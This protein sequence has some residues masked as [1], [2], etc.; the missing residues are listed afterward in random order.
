[1]ENVTPGPLLA[2]AGL[3]LLLLLGIG[4]QQARRQ[5]RF[6]SPRFLRLQQWGRYLAFA[7]ILLG[8]L[9]MARAK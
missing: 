2:L 7:F 6:A 8:L 1:M 5:A 4:R 9:L 3:I